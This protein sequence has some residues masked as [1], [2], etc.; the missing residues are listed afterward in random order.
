MIRAK[1]QLLFLYSCKH[2]IIKPVASNKSSLLLKIDLQNTPKLK[3]K[4]FAKSI[5]GP[6]KEAW[7]G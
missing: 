3:W 6:S 2:I 7:V 4:L 5:K 1:L